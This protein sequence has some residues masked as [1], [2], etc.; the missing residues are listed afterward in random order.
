MVAFSLCLL[1]AH[2][3]FVA[4]AHEQGVLL[5]LGQVVGRRR[6][7]LRLSSRFRMVMLLMPTL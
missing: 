2:I 4:V 5:G 7:A 3:D 1:D 6:L